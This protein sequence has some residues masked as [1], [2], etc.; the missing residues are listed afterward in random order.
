VR[1]HLIDVAGGGHL[2]GL[3]RGRGIPLVWAHGLLSSKELAMDA[4]RAVDGHRV[5]AFDQRGHG[6]SLRLSTPAEASLDHMALDI[7]AILDALEIDHAVLGGESM[8]AAAVLTFAVRHPHRVLRLL[9]DRPAFGEDGSNAYSWASEARAITA[10]GV[11]GWMQMAL[12]DLPSDVAL[13]VRA[14]YEPHW[15]RQEAQS[16]ATIFQALSNWRIPSFE[17]LRKLPHHALVRGW[18]GDIVHPL[19]LAEWIA[20]ALPHGHMV[21]VDRA[22]HYDVARDRVSLAECIAR[23]RQL[24]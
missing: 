11:D 12:S 13:Q 6:D 10:R 7:L 2:S 5:I 16:I 23:L 15:Q 21:L 24:N 22:L 19:S 3:E 8:G 4:L 1:S 20:S 18:P 9:I 14:R 17:A